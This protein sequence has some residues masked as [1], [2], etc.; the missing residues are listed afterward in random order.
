MNTPLDTLESLLRGLGGAFAYFTL[1]AIFYGIWRGTQRQAGRT[2]GRT[3]G[4]LRSKWFY[5]ITT[6][7]F[8]GISAWGW[9]P[10]P[11][12]FSTPARIALLA[13]G[14]AFYFP[15]L[16]L[17]LWGRLSLGRHY[18][19]STGTGAQL[20]QGQ[21]LITHG[22]YALV[23]HPMYLGLMAASIGS[24]LLYQTWTALLYTVFSP[25]I[26]LRARREEQALAA[27]FG[28]SWHEYCN[29]VPMLFPFRPEL[30]KK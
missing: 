15:G 16:S 18:F 21:P 11:L 4:W 1:A 27:E 10:L 2:S 9:Q 20:F 30:Q 8:F 22:P 6:L 19:V 17:M 5:L 26:L 24:L 23:R 7:I 13:S 28:E 29:R 25:F 14:A 3:P 12:A